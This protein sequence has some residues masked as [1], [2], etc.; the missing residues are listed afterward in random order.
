MT[1]KLYR[2]FSKSWEVPFQQWDFPGGEV[3]VKL[4]QEDIHVDEV[5]TV[6]VK[7]IPSSK[8]I[9]VALNLC[10]AVFNI[11]Q[12]KFKVTLQLE[13]FPYARQDRVCNKGESFALKVFVNMLVAQQSFGCLEVDDLHSEVTKQL[14]R[15][16]ATFTVIENTQLVCT[17]DLKRNYDFVVYP[18][19][20]ATKKA[21]SHATNSVVLSKVRREGKVEYQDYLPQLTGK[22]LVVDDIVDGG[23]TFLSLA[24][25]LKKGQ[26]GITQLDLYV[27]HGIF[28]KGVD[29]LFEF[30]DNIYCRNLMNTSVVGVKEI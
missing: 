13:Y 16:R 19:E 14:F 8:D 6:A 10:D 7:G 2:N 1:V 23:A 30:Y 22:V 26:P 18:D 29:K 11:V 4:N 20:G 15:Q 21:C 9:F 17:A 27:T 12:D 28:S 3:G 5:Y 24:E 25:M